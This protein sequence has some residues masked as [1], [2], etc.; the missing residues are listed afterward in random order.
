M[1]D[2][3]IIA[4]MVIA[5]WLFDAIFK[6]KARAKNK[7]EHPTELKRKGATSKPESSKDAGQPIS[8]KPITLEEIL[9]RISTKT[10]PHTA[11]KTT[12]HTPRK[13][14]PPGKHVQTQ[15]SKPFPPFAAPAKKTVSKTAEPES[16][17]T[18]KDAQAEQT[19]PKL[20]ASNKG[21]IHVIEKFPL[22]QQAVILHEIFLAPVSQRMRQKNNKMMPYSARRSGNIN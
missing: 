3:W 9:E 22:W 12:A 1:K 13:A 21:F 8:N 10:K 4:I 18:Q 5:S 20:P 17:E 11:P 14:T 2:F 7:Q 19:P 16:V 6:K 15:S